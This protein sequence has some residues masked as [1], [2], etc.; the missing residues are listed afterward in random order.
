MSGMKDPAAEPA[1]V[2]SIEA[3]IAKLLLRDDRGEW[4][5]FQ[6]PSS[7]LPKDIKERLISCQKAILCSSEIV[8]ICKKSILI[9]TPKGI[10]AT[11]TQQFV[12]NQLIFCV[13]QCGFSSK[14]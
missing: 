5:A 7:V 4:T 1:F 12:C 3:G 11:K 10:P 6:L 9:K 13:Y 8:K 2:D 14:I